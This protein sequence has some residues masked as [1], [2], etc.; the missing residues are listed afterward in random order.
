MKNKTKFTIK[1]KLKI[2]SWMRK[3]IMKHFSGRNHYLCHTY[4]DVLFAMD[5]IKYNNFSSDMSWFP[6]LKAEIIKIAT[7]HN[8][9]YKWNGQIEFDYKGIRLP[10][11]GNTS[12]EMNVYNE[13]KLDIISTVRQQ[14][15][16]G[17][18]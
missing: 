1:E 2:L 8:K 5:Y 15:T 12:H 16:K 7:K 11:N 3:N 10:G 18:Y 13:V 9:D 17:K 6:E 4:D 14:L